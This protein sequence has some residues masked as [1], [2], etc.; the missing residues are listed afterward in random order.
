MIK[1][2]VKTKI[3]KGH[4]DD[5][6]IFENFEKEFNN[7]NPIVARNEAFAHLQSLLEV[8][9]ESSQDDKEY[10]SKL[11]NENSYIEFENFKSRFHQNT[12]VSVY[13]M[14]DNEEMIIYFEGDFN[15]DT[16]DEIYFNLQE[17]FDFYKANDYETNNQFKF[18]TYFN[19]GEWDDGFTEDEPNSTYVLKTPADWTDKN[20][21]LWWDEERKLQLLK[22]KND[23]S[24]AYTLED[25]I[26]LGEGKTIEFK[27]ALVYNFNTRKGG[28]GIKYIIAKTIC[29]FLNTH[30]GLLFIGVS[31]DKKAVGL[32][33]DFS[34]SEA[35]DPYD[36]FKLEFDQ[37][38]SQFFSSSIH[39]KIQTSFFTYDEKDIFLI[40]VGKSDRPVFLKSKDKDEFWIR[41]EAS[42]RELVVIKDIIDHCFH[43]WLKKN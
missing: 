43:N 14:L 33:G 26:N 24:V 32:D 41:G 34:L 28:I 23:E 8:I 17:E 7:K 20:Q 18:I 30:G 11:I 36:F 38:I 42:T 35:K 39:S 2:I 29:S 27:S 21:E 5:K 19:K 3:I 6:N 4:I 25:L 16:W 10:Q 15:I 40:K 37:M 13:F 1:Y 9:K 12:G 31:D 22:F